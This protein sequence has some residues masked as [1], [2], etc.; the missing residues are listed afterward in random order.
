MISDFSYKGKTALITGASSGI[1]K[2]FAKKLAA[3]ECNLVITSRNSQIL[4]DVAGD[5]REQQGTAI[6]IEIISGD[7]AEEE[8]PLKLFDE[9]QKKK[10][11]I[12]LLINNAG[13]GSY[14]K[15]HEEELSLSRKMNLLNMVS[16]TDLCHLFLPPMLEKKSGGIINVASTAGFQPVPYMAVYSASKAYVKNLSLALWQEYK[17]MGIRIMA[18]CPGFTGTNFQKVSHT[19]DKV[20]KQWRI[21][22]P[23]QVVEEALQ[24]FNKGEPLY[25][26]SAHNSFLQFTLSKFISTKTALK[27]TED[28]FKP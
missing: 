10:I 25:I 24:A 11:H 5:I 17:D 18:L 2:E 22:E 1:G 12:D 15:F 16:L 6:D 19:P 13:F 14:G 8:T 9:I 4:Q 26:T 27:I 7:L 28:M 23:A 20:I 21:M 3:L